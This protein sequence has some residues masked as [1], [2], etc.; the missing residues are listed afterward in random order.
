MAPGKVEDNRNQPF[1]GPAGMLL[2][3]ELRRQ[4][5]NP[6]LAYYMNVVCCLPPNNVVKAGHVDACRGNLRDQLDTAEAEWVLVCGGT[7]ME[8]VIP[9]GN[10]HTRDRVIRIH[11]RKLWCVHHPSY[12]MRTKDTGVYKLWKDSLA[13]FGMAMRGF[14]FDVFYCM[15]CGG[16]SVHDQPSVC[17][18]KECMKLWNLDR[19]WKYSPP[20]QMR[21]E[22]L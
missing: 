22:G 15:Y 1:I 2:R 4:G 5:V 17:G 21:L 7:A 14:G 19:K 16:E 11:G 18:K 13:M 10:T 3:N 6:G 12:I 8:A 20:P 9:H